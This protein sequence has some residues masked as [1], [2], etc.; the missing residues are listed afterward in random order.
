MQHRVADPSTVCENFPLAQDHAIGSRVLGADFLR[1]FFAFVVDDF[2]LSSATLG[3]LAPLLRI[4]SSNRLAAA[5]TLADGSS[6][7]LFLLPPAPAPLPVPV[8]LLLP[9]PGGAGD[10][11]AP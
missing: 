3:L 4:S 11:D 9:L 2:F 6:A 7:F 5:F 1:F 10:A 8:T